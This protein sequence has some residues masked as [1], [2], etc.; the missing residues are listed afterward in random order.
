LREACGLHQ[1]RDMPSRSVGFSSCCVTRV[2]AGAD[3][4][5][6]SRPAVSAASRNRIAVSFVSAY[7]WTRMHTGDSAASPRRGQRRIP[8]DRA[9][10]PRP[11]R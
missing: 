4:P 9:P 7:A 1:A 6:H 2:G 3:E 5:R 10:R 11:R 8:S